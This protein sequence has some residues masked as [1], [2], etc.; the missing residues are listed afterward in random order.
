M[1]D[2]NA[3]L[4]RN[5]LGVFNERD[6]ETRLPV[7]RELY[8]PES[9]FSDHDGVAVGPDAID[10]KIRTLHARTPGFEFVP[11]QFYEVQDLGI[12]EWSAGPAGAEPVVRGTDV[13]I[14][15]DGYISELFVYLR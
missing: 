5:L 12:L 3:I 11:G 10:A 8:G 6:A 1:T 9:R 14:F 4:H 7:L 15:R 13:V 2:L